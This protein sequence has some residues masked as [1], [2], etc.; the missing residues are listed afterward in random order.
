MRPEL[1]NFKG[2]SLKDLPKEDF[3]AP[4]IEPVKDVER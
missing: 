3:I 1:A 4:G 2:L